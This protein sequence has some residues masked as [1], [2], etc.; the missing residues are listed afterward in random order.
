VSDGSI[1]FDRAAEY[2]D[3]TR[4]LPDHLQTQI[5]DILVD[6]LSGRGLC[7][8]PGVGTGRMALP[9]VG[10]DIPLVGIDLSLPM[11]ER[12]IAN[13]GGHAPF[14]LLRAD[15]TS[16]PFADAA[17]GAVFLCHVLHLVPAWRAAVREFVRV[18]RPPGIVLVDLGDNPN[19]V[20]RAVNREFARHAGQERPRPGV[21]ESTD[22]DAAM[23]EVGAPLARTRPIS[24]TH[25][26]ALD[27]YVRRLESNQ[28]SSTWGL[29][30]AT[31]ARAATATRE[32]AEREYGDLEARRSEPVEI[33][34]R[35]YAVT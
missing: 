12:L 15:V 21:T 22:L 3:R 29:D 7:L 2:Y 6:E 8:E 18:L 20:A 23:A 4:S 16:L 28:F 33:V 34:W 30:D 14:P 10:R 19:P 1:V 5:T 32:W 35:V 27:D 25:H 24:F 11:M 31:R 9:L 26:Y 17:F 13:S